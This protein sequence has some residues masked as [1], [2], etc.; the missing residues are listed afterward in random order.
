V[1]PVVKQTGKIVL[2]LVNRAT[3]QMPYK[4][5]YYALVKKW[6]NMPFT[7]RQDSWNKYLGVDKK[8]VNYYDR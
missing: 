3:T 1:Q 8:V 6:K 7:V 5:D 2:L 4:P